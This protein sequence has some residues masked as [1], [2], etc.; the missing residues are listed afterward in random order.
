VDGRRQGQLSR[1]QSP[2]TWRSGTH[3]SGT[4]RSGIHRTGT[5][6]SGTVR[7]AFNRPE[8]RNAF[9]PQLCD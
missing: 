4:H 7:I 6:R 2:D 3:R 9:R 1:S 5:H 8:V